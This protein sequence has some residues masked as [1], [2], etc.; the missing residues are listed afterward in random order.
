M[1]PEIRKLTARI[2]RLQARSAEVQAELTVSLA[3]K[4]VWPEAWK[5]DSTVTIC[6]REVVRTMQQALRDRKRGKTPELQE[7][8]LLRS[9]GIRFPLTS[10]V[11]W[12]LKELET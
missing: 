3:I 10:K 7:C 1:N 2:K 5:G 8:Y 4:E 9:D 6:A 12:M 11:Y